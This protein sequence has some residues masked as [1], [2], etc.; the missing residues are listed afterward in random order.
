[1]T[2]R[3]QRPLR[4]TVRRTGRASTVE[5]VLT[6]CRDERCLAGSGDPCFK[7]GFALKG[8]HRLRQTDAQMGVTR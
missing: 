4:K 2:T 8:F 5:V 1:M 7:D 6:P 3:A